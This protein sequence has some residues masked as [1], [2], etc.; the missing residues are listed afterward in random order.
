M[1]GVAIVTRLTNSLTGIAPNRDYPSR[2]E[3]STSASVLYAALRTKRR[4]AAFS[5]RIW[6][7]EY[8]ASKV[9]SA[10]KSWGDG[11]TEKLVWHVVKEFRRPYRQREA[12]TPRPEE[13]MC[14]LMSGGHR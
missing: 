9:S 12:G 1:R 11:V 6:L 2:Q 3:Q 14:A 13:D 10:G 7:Q 8:G 4:T 5:A